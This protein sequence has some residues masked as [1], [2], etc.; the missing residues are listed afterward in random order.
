MT[1]LL[2]K[3]NLKEPID[4]DKL[5]V[6]K[7]YPE[8]ELY[9][10]DF[11]LDSTPDYVWEQCFER[12]ARIAILNLQR[13]VKIVGNNLRITAPLNEVNKGMIEGIKKLVNATNQCVEEY[14][15]EMLQREKVE[16]AKKKEEQEDIKKMREA[17]K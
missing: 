14:D 12:E 13:R 6:E 5:N 16:Q 7:A 2:R 3:V 1:R 8:K 10:V 15:K 11:P 9:N 17:I 4:P